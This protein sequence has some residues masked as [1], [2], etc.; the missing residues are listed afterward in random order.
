M[1]C[2]LVSI[3]SRGDVV[4]FVGLGQEL[5]S[6]GNRVRVVVLES[7][8]PLVRE[9]GLEACPVPRGTEALWPDSPGMR[10]LALAQPGAMWGQMTGRVTLAA[11]AILDTLTDALDDA[12]LVVSGILTHD[13][14]RLLAARRGTTSAGLLLGPILPSGSAAST[15]LAPAY[16]PAPVTLG[17]STVGWQMMRSMGAAITARALARVGRQ[18]ARASRARP[19]PLLLATEPVLCTPDP[20]WA[21]GVGALEV[22][23]TGRIAPRLDSTVPTWLDQWLEAHPGAVLMGF[24]TCPVADERADLHLFE[25]AARRLGRPL[26]VQTSLLPT[27]PAGSTVANAPGVDHR[28][29]LARLAAVVHH[30]GAGTTATALSSGRPQ[31]VI[32]HLGD[33]AWHARRV[34]E[35]GAGTSPGPR[36]R[37][38]EDALVWALQGAL[39]T[40]TVRR[41]A[42][43]AQMASSPEDDGA[44]RAADHLVGTPAHPSSSCTRCAAA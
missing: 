4:P 13:A 23:Q 34:R 42:Q 5:A 27:G 15:V 29:L 2:T 7:G 8:A 24:G 26:L 31:V 16:L 38:R 21:H 10:R 20:S 19:G 11:G 32:P 44:R 14:T 36:W 30:G 41:A 1:R 6:R 9:A 22:H 28:L 18:A 40:P 12:D 17:V 25:V 3:G 35:L 33:Q 43:V 37:L 39:A